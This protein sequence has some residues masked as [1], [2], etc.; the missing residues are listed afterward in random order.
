MT[1]CKPCCRLTCSDLQRIFW[2]LDA[3]GVQVDINAVK[4]E[5]RC[6]RSRML[7]LAFRK[8]SCAPSINNHVI[9]WC[10]GSYR[11]NKILQAIIRKKKTKENTLLHIYSIHPRKTNLKRWDITYYK[12][13]SIYHYFQ[14]I[15]YALALRP[16]GLK[17]ETREKRSTHPSTDLSPSKSATR[18]V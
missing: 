6:R 9:R 1:A 14:E 4:K 7:P 15:D 13:C 12:S 18:I 17:G 16:P 2:F 8:V 3:K 11:H 5:Q 10:W